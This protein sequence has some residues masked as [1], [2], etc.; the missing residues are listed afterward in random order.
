MQLKGLFYFLCASIVIT[1][2]LLATDVLLS[3]KLRPCNM[4]AMRDWLMKRPFAAAL[5]VQPMLVMPLSPSPPLGVALTFRRKPS[6]EKGLT[7]GGLR[8]ALSPSSQADSQ[9]AVVETTLLVSRISEGQAVPKGLSERILI[10][11]VT[12]E[13]ETLPE[14]VGSVV[15]VL[16]PDRLA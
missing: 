13:L 10:N 4:V 11:F 2:A 1:D 14:E 3:V 8:F 6:V 9:E 7:E 5:P 15:A 16:R 12:Q